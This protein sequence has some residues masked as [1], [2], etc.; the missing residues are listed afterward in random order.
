MDPDALTT[1]ARVLEECDSSLAPANYSTP[2]Q[3]PRKLAAPGAPRKVAMKRD[4]AMRF[5]PR[6]IEEKTF[7]INVMDTIR[8]RMRGHLV[9][10]EKTLIKTVLD[11]HLPKTIKDGLPSSL[12]WFEYNGTTLFPSSLGRTTPA[13]LGMEEGDTRT[14][15]SF[16]SL[17][18]RSPQRLQQVR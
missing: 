18:G 17:Q 3:S 16:W 15:R 13:D 9:E 12:L 6:E 5:F 10:G 1:A 2:P 8:G 14:S 4:K 11:D 7:Q